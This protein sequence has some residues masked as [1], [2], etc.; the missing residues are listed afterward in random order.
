MIQEDE[1]FEMPFEDILE[2]NKKVKKRNHQNLS[3]CVPSRKD[4]LELEK[5]KLSD[6]LIT[7]MCHSPLEI[8]PSIFQISEVLYLLEQRPDRNDI[9]S[10]INMCKQYI[11]ND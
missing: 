8:I 6:V 9:T 10:L 5:E 4:I 1:H 2:A 11:R 7:W 3:S